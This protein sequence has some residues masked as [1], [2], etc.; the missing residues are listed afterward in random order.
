MCATSVQCLLKSY[1][2][3]HENQCHGENR[4]FRDQRSVESFSEGE[5]SG[6]A[7]SSR[8]LDLHVLPDVSPSFSGNGLDV[9][10]DASVF[11]INREESTELSG[12]DG[13]VG[14]DESLEVTSG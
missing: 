6:F 9:R 3:H 14:F 13:L 10:E 12:D 5:G 11:I 2:S 7:L 4:R 1:P 8:E